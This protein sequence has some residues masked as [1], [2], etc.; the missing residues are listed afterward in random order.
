MN[1]A[2]LTY[3]LVPQSSFQT[4]S[5]FEGILRIWKVR[6]IIVS[7]RFCF[8]SSVVS[9]KRCKYFPCVNQYGSNLALTGVNVVV[10]SSFSVVNIIIFL[11]PL[12]EVFE[13]VQKGLGIH[14][15]FSRNLFQSSGPRLGSPQLQHSPLS[16]FS[17]V[18]GTAFSM[19]VYL[20]WCYFPSDN[21]IISQCSLLN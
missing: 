5:H 19:C 9:R 12:I 18:K 13:V 7:P 14:S 11:E 6:R 10:P 20:Y 3:S 8:K 2:L 17:L 15:G 4:Q 16:K 21:S 1:S